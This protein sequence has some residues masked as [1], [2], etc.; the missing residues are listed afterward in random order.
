MRWMRASALVLVTAVVAGTAGF[1]VGG[2][3]GFDEGYT[4]ASHTSDVV[5]GL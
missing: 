4:L 1:A 2:R 3:A 5:T